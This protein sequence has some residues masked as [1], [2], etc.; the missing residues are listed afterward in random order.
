MGRG[1]AD[2]TRRAVLQMKDLLLEV[3]SELDEGLKPLGVTS[4]QVKVLRE[5]EERG[6]IT[7]AQAARLCHVTP[8]TVQA[9]LVRCEREGWLE[10]SADPE[11]ERLVL[12][13]LSAEGR[14]L[15][16]EA[17][18]VFEAV[19][20]RLWAGTSVAEIREV[21]GLLAGFLER[22]RSRRG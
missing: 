5:V 11:N 10:R 2:E 14:R 22:I 1:R 19:Q 13:S 21:N 7:G 15:A 17:E 18:A 8:Q 12:W 20:E 16:R 4:A 9:L 3:R 6:R